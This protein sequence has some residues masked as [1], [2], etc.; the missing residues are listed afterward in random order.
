MNLKII[1]IIIVNKRRLWDTEGKFSIEDYEVF[2]TLESTKRK[3]DL[4]FELTKM[5]KIA[6]VAKT[7]YHIA[8]TKL[9][10]GV[11]KMEVDDSPDS[12]R[13]R[14]KKYLKERVARF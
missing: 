13:D 11:K 2:Q 5:P 9:R 10:R 4:L 8:L 3:T 14:T 1:I 12:K 6:D 7:D